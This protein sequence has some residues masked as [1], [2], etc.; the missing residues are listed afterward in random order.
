[1][2]GMK[3][4]PMKDGVGRI[5]CRA[6]F[7]ATGYT[8]EDIAAPLI[9]IV[10]SWTDAFPGHM[11]LNQISQSVANGIYAAGGTPMTFSTIA[12]CDGLCNGMEG[13]KFSLP[14]RE[15]IA[16]SIESVARA[17][18]FDGLVFVSACDK[19]VPGMMMAACRLDIP[20]IFVN[21]GPMMPGKYKDRRLDLTSLGTVA[22][23]LMT[24]KVSKEDY[25][26]V[27]DAALPGCGSCA[28]MFTANSM[29]CMTEVL[30]LAL[31]GNG[32][33]PAVDAARLR[34]ARRSGRRVVELV[35]EDFKPSDFITK[36][37]FENA[38]SMDMLIGCSTNTVLHLPAIAHE[39]GITVSL[40]DFDRIGDHTPSVCHISPAGKFYLCDLH[41]AGGMQALMK[42]AMD[43]GFLHSECRTVSG[44]TLREQLEAVRVQNSDVIRPLDNPYLPS[45]GLTVLRGNL[46]P[47]GA[48]IKANAVEASMFQ[49]EGIAKVFNSEQ[50]AT[51]AL[52][53]GKIQ[54]GDAVVVR[55]EGPK[56]GPG[57]QEMAT[58]IAF[59]QGL[60]LDDG[61]FLLTDGRFSGIT[62]GASI[63]H[64]SPEAWD[65]G[66]IALVE[67]GDH[68][69]FDI[70]NKTLELLV[71]D[72]EL[73][74]R[75]SKWQR[76][77]PRY[78]KGYLAK[79]AKTV[80]SVTEGAIT[81]KG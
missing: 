32:T 59:M 66:P 19:I 45:G 15:L 28:G 75:R 63:G 10:N 70:K 13:M 1:M 9:G 33:I 43:G 55:Y 35:K 78:T 34:L 18:N 23:G 77:T 39:L 67:D 50:E 31:P 17:H 76:P 69:R 48:V 2:E 46:A 56:G 29:G 65:G 71:S 20:C 73:A 79:Y 7:K 36:E 44:K 8:D 80:S 25:D 74:E 5:A 58:L 41:D 81:N 54:K 6:L 52:L 27:E 61:I 21:G 72:E 60:G 14:S 3:S 62:R 16:D 12:I 40:D 24:G 37:T 42:E 53:A 22:G 47:E 4:I 68:I 38:I 26:A 51:N 64:V 30:G 11:H 57:M 49:Q